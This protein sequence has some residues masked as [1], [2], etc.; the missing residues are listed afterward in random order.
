MIRRMGLRA[1][2][3]VAALT[4]AACASDN[5]PPGIGATLA[6]TFGGVVLGR[7][8][9]GASPAS[10]TAADIATL[11][12]PAVRVLV[13]AT[14]QSLI[15][16]GVAR[17]DRRVTYETPDGGR[18]VVLMDGILVATRG[19]GADL[20][21]TRVGAL[22]AI[23]ARGGASPTA[24]T[25]S[26]ETLSG[27]DAIRVFEVPCAAVREGRETVE[28]G[29]RTVD[30]VKITEGCQAGGGSTLL[31]Y[32]WLS[33]GRVVKSSQFVA[34]GLGFIEIETLR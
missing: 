6:K 16:R 25:R 18:S 4:L 7:G 11:D 9:D 17:N 24:Y 19:F 31:N 14:G 29:G 5:R 22:P 8:G 13:N 15:M 21:G 34:D 30:A 1:A 27:S 32:Y 3:L 28:V 12:G 33:G 23:L 26:Y 10:M 2:A 20:M